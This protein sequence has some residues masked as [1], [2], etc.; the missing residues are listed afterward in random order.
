[1]EIRQ[2]KETDTEAIEFIKTRLEDWW[3]TSQK[4]IE[5]DYILPS[6]KGSFPYIFIALTPEQELAG[7]IFLSKIEKSFLNLRNKVWIEGLFVKEKFRGQ[8]IARELIK[9]AEQKARE[10]GYKKLY[11]DTAGAMEYYFK[12]GDWKVV[13]KDIW[14]GTTG[15]IIMVKDLK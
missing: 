8:G 14:K 2:L 9:T 7:K 6:F 13:G 1:M 3:E 12:L 15:V 5:N 10:L 4:E 11:L